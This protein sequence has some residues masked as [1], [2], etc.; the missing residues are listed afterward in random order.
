MIWKILTMEHFV[1]KTIQIETSSGQ[2]VML[3]NHRHN[4]YFFTFVFIHIINKSV[5]DYNK[6]T[7]TNITNM[8]NKFMN[9]VLDCLH[10]HQHMYESLHILSSH[11]ILP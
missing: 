4:F 8:A 3:L 5:I 9:I 7:I 11:M 10:K 6:N 2:Y 1:G